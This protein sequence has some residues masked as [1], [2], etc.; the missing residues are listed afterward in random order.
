VWR[1]VRRHGH[2]VSD[3]VLELFTRDPQERRELRITRKYVKPGGRYGYVFTGLALALP[4]SRQRMFLWRLR[5]DARRIAPEDLEDLLDLGWRERQTA[6]WLIAAGR[7]SDVRS[8]LAQLP[9]GPLAM[10]GYGLALAR[11]GT[12]RDAMLLEVYL[13]TPPNADRDDGHDRAEALAALL[14]LDEQLGTSRGQA[15]LDAAEA[16]SDV[17]AESGHALE[18][19]LILM[20]GGVPDLR[21]RFIREGVYASGWRG[22]RHPR[23]M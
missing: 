5:R 4:R 13:R 16:N 1:I 18:Q 8:R 11:L 17:L 2:F 6:F 19:E 22:W 10:T 21:D 14:H 7:R 12:D 15:F 20:E 9:G 3:I 23:S